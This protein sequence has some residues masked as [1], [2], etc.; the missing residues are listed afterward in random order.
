MKS[1]GQSLAALLNETLGTG[2]LPGVLTQSFE[3]ETKMV[4]DQGGITADE[5][6]VQLGDVRGKGRLALDL[7]EGTDVALELAVQRMD[8]DTLLAL[9]SGLGVVTEPDPEEQQ[10][11]SGETVQAPIPRI[12]KR[13]PRASK[14]GI[15]RGLPCRW[16][17]QGSVDLTINAMTYKGGIMSRARL[18]AD[19]ADGEI[20]LSQL[21]AQMPGGSDVAVLRHREC[22]ARD[23]KV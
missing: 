8:V 6:S 4:A 7:S 14:P 10:A 16:M 13:K 2:A 21:S 1:K 18:T 11:Q 3:I 15:K 17:S 9:P 22:C 5:L 12:S 23:A 20:T 19:L